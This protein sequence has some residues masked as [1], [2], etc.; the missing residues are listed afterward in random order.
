MYRCAPQRENADSDRH[1]QDCPIDNGDRYPRDP[2]QLC[3]RLKKSNNC[4]NGKRKSKRRLTPPLSGLPEERKPGGG[5]VKPR[6]QLRDSVPEVPGLIK[7]SYFSDLAL[8]GPH[9]VRVFKRE[10]IERLCDKA[11]MDLTR[12]P[13]ER[14]LFDAAVYHVRKAPDE[15]R[16]D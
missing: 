16:L 13:Y 5:L 3:V 6:A 14:K 8:A 15:R 9:L 4:N 12:S 2:V 1:Q 11:Q 7:G 10:K